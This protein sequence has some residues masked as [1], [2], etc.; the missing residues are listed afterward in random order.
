MDE[1]DAPVNLNV[2]IR[3]LSPGDNGDVTQD[4][5]LP[6]WSD[7]EGGGGAPGQPLNWTWTWNWTWTCES[8]ATTAGMDWN[9]DWDWDC[10]GLMPDADDIPAMDG[11]LSDPR[12]DRPELLFGETPADESAEM[13]PLGDAPLTSADRPR[14]SPPGAAAP[15]RSSGDP[16][17]QTLGLVE[18]YF[19]L[20]AAGSLAGAASVAPDAAHAT[21]SPRQQ[22][23]G[24]AA[25]PK[26]APTVSPSAAAS[27][28]SGGSSAPFAAALLGLLCL[29][30]PRALEL[31]PSPHRKL[32]SLL[33]SSRL[34]RPG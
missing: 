20:I 23:G 28:P 24:R 22:N 18:P 11:G 27:S 13:V 34:E 5:T 16:P 25:A 29:L 17:R 4:M 15:H 31:A 9:W 26:Q 12:L 33:S 6:G 14:P 8:G 30:A 7:R 32:S 1:V 19:P 2:D 21:P 3:I 10:G